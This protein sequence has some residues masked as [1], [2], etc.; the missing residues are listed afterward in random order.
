MTTVGKILVVLH[1][2]L[3]IV[4][5]AFAGAVFTAQTNWKL[6]EKAALTKLAKA[7]STIKEVQA[8]SEKLKSDFQLD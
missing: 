4:F 5:M 6:A 8:E 1:L 3:S 7:E 2:V